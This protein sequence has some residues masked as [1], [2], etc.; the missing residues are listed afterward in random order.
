MPDTIAASHPSARRTPPTMSICHSSIAR[1]RLPPPVVAART[2]AG[3]RDDQPVVDQAPVDRRR[4]G[5]G[6][7]PSWAS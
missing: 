7:T 6:A 2:C 1:E 5:T 3:L 4:P